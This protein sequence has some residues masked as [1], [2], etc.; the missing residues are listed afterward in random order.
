MT[1]AELEH[2]TGQTRDTKEV[3]LYQ[4]L[5]RAGASGQDIANNPSERAQL[6]LLTNLEEANRLR[7]QARGK[8]RRYPGDQFRYKPPAARRADRQRV[9]DGEKVYVGPI[10]PR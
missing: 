4:L 10:G 1:L 5:L 3:V 6:D 7:W 8:L 9:A 2:I